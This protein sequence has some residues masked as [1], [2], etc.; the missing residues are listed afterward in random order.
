MPPVNWGV[1]VPGIGVG[2][3]PTGITGTEDASSFGGQ[4]TRRTS[5]MVEKPLSSSFNIAIGFP[6]VAPSP[7]NGEA[8][9]TS[10]IFARNIDLIVGPW[11]I[12]DNDAWCARLRRRRLQFVGRHLCERRFRKDGATSSSEYKPVEIPTFHRNPP[13]CRFT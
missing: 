12:L 6:G 10:R 9:S 3:V 7:V 2:G 5:V 11:G 13:S 4:A 8:A 1:G